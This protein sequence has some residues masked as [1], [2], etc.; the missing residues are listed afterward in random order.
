MYQAPTDRSFRYLVDPLFLSCVCVYLVNRLLLK[1]YM[2]NPISK[3][4]LNDLLCIPFGLPIMVAILNTLR[5]RLHDLTPRTVE[6]AVAIVIW[7]LAF[8]IIIPEVP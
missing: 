5:L 7:S 4:Y 8:E 3:G 2:L 1:P 6:I